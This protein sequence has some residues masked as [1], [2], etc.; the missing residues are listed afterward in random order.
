MKLPLKYGNTYKVG[1]S[2]T[3]STGSCEA[4]QT[5]KWIMT[6]NTH[7]MDVLKMYKH[8]N[9]KKCNDKISP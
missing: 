5:Q 2:K 1:R 8:M 7:R 6:S 9:S 4:K 3:Q